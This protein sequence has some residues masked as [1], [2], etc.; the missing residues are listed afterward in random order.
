[1]N[2]IYMDHAASTPVHP[3]VA[4]EMLRIMTGTYGNASSVHAFGRDA[5]RIASSSREKIAAAINARPADLVFTSGGTESDNTALFGAALARAE[6]GRHLLVS[7]IEHHA[8]LHAAERLEQQGFEVEYIPVDVR[9]R[10]DV[11]WIREHARPDTT[12]ISVMFANNEVGTVQPVR[13][14]GAFARECGIWFHTDAVQALGSLPIDC[15]DLNAD[16]ISFSAH[17]INGPQGIGALY[18]APHVKLPALLYGGNQERKRRAGTENLAGMAGFAKAAELAVSG[19]EERHKEAL[20][21]RGLFLNG[22][23]QSIG[24]DAF[25][26]NGDPEHTL[27][28]IANISFPAV[29][30][31]T[32]LMN[33][34]ME[35]IA[36][37]SG[38]ACTS[39]SLETSHV[40]R[41]MNLSEKVLH[42]AIR[43]SFGLGNTSEEI[44]T[45]VKK[46]ETITNRM[47]NKN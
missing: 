31:E 38:S 2:R 42:S 47:R 20:R 1:M 35:G 5:K 9:G 46:I 33:L 39:G 36:A 12:L 30:T 21:L 22:L 19:L 25:V 27:A 7:R 29:G 18:V 17:K 8:V 11:Q 43:F 40:L 4:E 44:E 37:A 13:E 3:L 26:L 34:D 24:E 28:H 14:I 6:Q 41:A 10:V 15:A 16:L 45:V 23:E 32:M